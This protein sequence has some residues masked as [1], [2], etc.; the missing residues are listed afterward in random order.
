MIDPVTRDI[1]QNIYLR[2]VEKQNGVLVN[3]EF[4]TY[5]M[6]VSPEK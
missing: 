3:A 2:R 5:P 4:A 1:V 6:V